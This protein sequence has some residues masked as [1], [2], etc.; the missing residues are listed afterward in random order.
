VLHHPGIAQLYFTFQVRHGLHALD[1]AAWAA[2]A[3][4]PCAATR[5]AAAAVDM[6]R[7]TPAPPPRPPSLP[8]PQDAESLYMGLEYCPNG[9]LYQ[10]LEARGPLPLADTVQWAAEI[11]DILEYLR[12]KEVIHRWTAA[13]GCGCEGLMGTAAWRTDQ[14][15][16]GSC[17]L[18]A[19]SVSACARGPC[20]F[21]PR[22]D[23]KPENLLLDA[24]G[25]LKLIDFGSAKALFLP[26]A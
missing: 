20:C 13:R 3:L 15:A 19:R 25:H 9:E 5:A 2:C 1:G 22:R 10:Q 14:T 16:G 23:L 12:Q 7:L 11:V 17:M 8:S 6:H 4:V 24:E 18:R 26:P 21:R